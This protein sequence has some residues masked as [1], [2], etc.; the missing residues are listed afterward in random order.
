MKVINL[1]SYYKFYVNSS[2]E[3]E[4]LKYAFGENNIV[5]ENNYFTFQK[6]KNMFNYTFKGMNFNNTNLICRVN[7]FGEKFEILEKNQIV[8]DI[9]EQDFKNLIDIKQNVMYNMNDD[10]VLSIQGLVQS[11]AK[12][13]G[14]IVHSFS[15]YWD[16]EEAGYLYLE[17]IN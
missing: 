16:L 5:Q 14:E 17:S 2:Y 3:L 4:L 10:K 7:Y 15:G 6:L 11:G 13:N 12:L 1:Y 8:F 9:L